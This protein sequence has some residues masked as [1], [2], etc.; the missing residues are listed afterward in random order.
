L[1]KLHLHAFACICMCMQLVVGGTNSK[2]TIVAM[3][4]W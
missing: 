4:P 3:D 1:K 2:L